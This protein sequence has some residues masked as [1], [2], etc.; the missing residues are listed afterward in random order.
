M[1]AIFVRSLVLVFL[2]NLI[3]K[4]FYI[5]GIEVSVQNI[6][7]AETYGLFFSLFNFTYLFQIINDMGLQHYNAKV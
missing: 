1:N 4:P 5:F 7:G 3:I 6:L 2:V